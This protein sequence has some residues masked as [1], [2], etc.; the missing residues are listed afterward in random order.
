MKEV[1]LTKIAL[2]FLIS[3]L[4]SKE[5]HTFRIHIIKSTKGKLTNGIEVAALQINIAK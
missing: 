3:E 1:K 5:K 2:F 4:K